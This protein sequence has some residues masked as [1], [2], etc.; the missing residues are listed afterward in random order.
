MAPSL[1]RVHG[2]VSTTPAAGYGP[3]SWSKSCKF[4]LQ[5]SIPAPADGQD[6]ENKCIFGANLV[7][8]SREDV[9]RVEI[10]YSFDEG[11]LT[12]LLQAIE[13]KQFKKEAHLL[14]MF[15]QIKPP[16]RSVGGNPLNVN[17]GDYDYEI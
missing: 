2:T 11:P 15:I 7:P 14:H 9:F 6:T 12:L 3:L 17:G 10:F 13:N 8:S 16:T 4:S 1:V 5:F